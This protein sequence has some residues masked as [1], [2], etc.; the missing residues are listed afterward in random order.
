M[1][2]ALRGQGGFTLVETI[3]TI[4]VGAIVMAAIFPIFFA[5]YRA[6][7][8]WR[9]ASQARVTGLMAEDTLLRDLRA[10]PVDQLDPLTLVAPG[11]Q[12]YFVDY[13]VD[14]SGHLIRTVRVGEAP[15][16]SAV[17]ARGIG[18]LTA[19]CLDGSVIQVEI[20]MAGSK[21]PLDAPLVVRP[22]N[23][24]VCAH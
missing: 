18:S 20:W 12:P 21:V 14:K 4:T 23:S 17:I 5:L 19:S 8:I 6:E 13:S 1:M 2:R 24:P 9:N 15:V 22:R 3:V 16:S 10:Y 7:S 11:Q